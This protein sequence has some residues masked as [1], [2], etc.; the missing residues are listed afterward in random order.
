MIH[1]KTVEALTDLVT[2]ISGGG[3][4]AYNVGP[5]GDGSFDPFDQ[6]VLDNIAARQQRRPRAISGAQAT[7]F[8][9]P[10]WGRITANS[11]ELYFFL[12]T[13][14]WRSGATVSLAGLGNEV[15]AV[16]I[17]GTDQELSFTKDGTKLDITLEGDA[18]DEVLNVLKVSLDGEPSM[19]PA[20]SVSAIG[21]SATVMDAEVV[22]R[23]G[24]TWRSCVRC[25]CG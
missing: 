10:D 9:I 21:G 23:A 20:T 24:Q 25:L 6:Q 13:N 7:W 18:P 11:S 3:Q 5:K 4:Y 17:D 14:N 22:A 16:H 1:T 19:I 8:P 15:N 12:L 2:V